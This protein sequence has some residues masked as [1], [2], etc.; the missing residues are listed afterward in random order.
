[1]FKTYA[2]LRDAY[3]RG[4]YLEKYRLLGQ[5]AATSEAEFFAVVSELFFDKPWVLKRHF[6]DLY[7]ELEAFY[8]LDTAELFKSL[9]YVR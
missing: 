1:M 9:E 7:K 3:E 4:R 5:Y 2:K 8:G 6:P